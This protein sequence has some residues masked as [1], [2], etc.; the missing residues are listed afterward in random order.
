MK[1]A[2]CHLHST[3]SDA[4]FTPEQLVLIGKSLGYG[5]LAL[6][7]HET[8]GGCQRLMRAAEAEGIAAISGV[9]FYGTE[10]GLEL[11]LVALD[12]D[13]ND[14]GIR[15]YIKERCDFARDVA[16]ARFEK[17]LQMGM[18]GGIT[19][20]DVLDRCEEGTWICVDTI[21]NTLKA[22]KCIPDNFDWK[23][24]YWTLFKCPEAKAMELPLVDAE[25]VIR[26][27]R[28]AGGVIALAHPR[29]QTYLV[30]KLVSYGLNGIEVSHPNLYENTAYLAAEAAD[31]FKLYRCGG[32]D[33]TGPMSGCGG[34]NAIQAFQGITYEEFE[35][36]K[37]RRLG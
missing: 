21:K 31:T 30:E 22:K 5:A 20:Q 36:L 32:T 18:Y 15:A 11:H 37:E 29:K 19:F 12:F 17:G 6:T 34:V 28:K 7:D 33:H 23:N 4:Q 27:V 26:T 13:Q 16:K 35:T 2:N 8:D 10:D 3:F 1:Y 9:E 24:F 25:R 14:P